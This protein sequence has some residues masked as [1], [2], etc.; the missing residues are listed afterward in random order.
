LVI[1]EGEDNESGLDRNAAAVVRVLADQ[2]IEP[3]A[4]EE[5]AQRFAALSARVHV[6]RERAA[7]ARK[8]RRMLAVV[9]CLALVAGGAGLALRAG[10]GS[11]RA[12]DQ[13]LTYSLDGAPPVPG[14]YI[15]P[16]AS[17]AAQTLSFS[18]GTQI[19][20]APASR[21]RVVETT[22]QGGRVALE[23]G[24]AHVNVIHRPGAQ[25][26]FEAGPFLIHVRGTTFSFAWSGRDSRFE[27]QMEAGVVSVTGPVS[28]GEIVL[29]GGQKLAIDLRDRRPAATDA[30]LAPPPPATPPVG[31]PAAAQPR[32][33]RGGS[34]WAPERWAGH[35]EQGRAG[36]ILAEARRMGLS[37][38]LEK[39]TAEQ[40]AILAT[41][42][43]FQRDD[44][45]ARRA[46]L[47]QRRRFPHSKRGLEASFL[48]G[49]LDDESRGDT[50]SALGW[51]DRYLAEA[52]D[53]A[54]VAEALG[55]KMVALQHSGRHAQAAEIAADYLRRFPTGAYAH[56][57]RALARAP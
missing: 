52:P 51:Y 43:R 44:E 25:W 55:R 33:V 47:T 19:K 9:G 49:R 28:G 40:L 45:L 54:Y 21:A 22:R 4:P 32:V 14:G 39:T 12:T 7:R 57:A 38:A 10:I 35:L 37:L 8:R 29:R 27:V 26:V 1:A 46:L 2:N 34:A 6:W 16:A 11:G 13:P 18:D 53:G 50:A 23:D 15:E 48:L 20:V 42:A 31:S 17:T 5:R 36:L 24:H 30:S 3:H 41:A 56:A